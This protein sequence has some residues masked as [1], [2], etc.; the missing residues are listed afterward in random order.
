M[1]TLSDSIE[2]VIGKLEE[3]REKK[4]GEIYAQWPKI[5]G[6]LFS[7]HCSPVDLKEGTLIINVESSAWMYMLRLKKG[8]ILQKLNKISVQKIQ[9]VKLRIGKIF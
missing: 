7:R 4:G 6:V 2:K 8:Q 5:V 9:A 3:K 1:K